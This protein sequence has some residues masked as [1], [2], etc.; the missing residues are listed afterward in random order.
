[1]ELL[2]V[3]RDGSHSE[4]LI[5]NWDEMVVHLFL[6]QIDVEM[7]KLAAQNLGQ[8]GRV[9]FSFFRSHS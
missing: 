9:N 1:M 5:A 8:E 3:K 6:D 2:R 4:Q 7:A